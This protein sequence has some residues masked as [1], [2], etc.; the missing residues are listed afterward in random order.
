VRCETVEGEFIVT[1]IGVAGTDGEMLRADSIIDGALVKQ[2]EGWITVNLFSFFRC[3]RGMNLMSCVSSRTPNAH[4][5][6]A[7]AFFVRHWVPFLI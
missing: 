7:L 1:S 5:E 4:Y 6:S 3:A 2:N